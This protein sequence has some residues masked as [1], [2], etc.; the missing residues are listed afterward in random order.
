MVPVKSLK[1]AAVALVGA[2]GSGYALQML[3]GDPDARSVAGADMAGPSPARPNASET[4]TSMSGALVSLPSSERARGNQV[5]HTAALDDADGPALQFTPAPAADSADACAMALDLTPGAAGTLTATLS[6]PCHG[7]ERVTITHDQL[8]FDDRM[9]AEGPLLVILPALQV[10][11]SVQMI[12]PGAAPQRARARVPQAAAYHRTVLQWSGTG[13]FALHAFYGDAGFDQPGHLHAH[14]PVDAAAEGAFTLTL[15]KDG[16]DHPQ[17]AHVH[18]TPVDSGA[19][20]LAIA[21]Q[22]T[23]QTCDRVIEAET[24]ATGAI[25]APVPVA[26]HM[27]S[28]ETAG[29]FALLPVP[30]SLTLAAN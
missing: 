14:N 17:L 7:G 8:R 24:F 18:S 30:Q 23:D 10:D 20:R 16:L 4:G 6:A 9:P 2:L 3:E 19:P 12:L 21:A 15:G 13:D 27:D 25:S 5:V 11:A 1:L 22:H 29:G 26:V 28:C